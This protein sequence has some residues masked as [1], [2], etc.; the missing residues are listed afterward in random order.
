LGNPVPDSDRR[1]PRVELPSTEEFILRQNGNVYLVECK[2]VA[3]RISLTDA[4][5]LL[6]HKL[7]Y[8]Q[9]TDLPGKGILLGNAWRNDP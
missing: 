1:Q 4:R 9:Q 2:G 6:N 3:K 7:D 8:E 5:Q